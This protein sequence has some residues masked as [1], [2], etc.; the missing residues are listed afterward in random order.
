MAKKA[1]SSNPFEGVRRFNPEEEKRGIPTEAEVAKLLN[2]KWENEAM[3]LG[4]RVIT[5]CGL[6]PTELAGLKVCDIDATNDLIHVRNSWN[7]IDKLKDTKN[8]DESTLPIDHE[9]L[10]SWCKR[11]I[12]IS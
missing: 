6:R 10:G 12:H 4:F 11:K 8:T 5:F 7:E 9:T 1:L 2:L 3:Y